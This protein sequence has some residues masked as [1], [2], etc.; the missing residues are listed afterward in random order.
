MKRNYSKNGSMMLADD[1][2]KIQFDQNILS[3]ALFASL[4]F[5]TQKHVCIQFYYS[6]RLS[7]L[8][9]LLKS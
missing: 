2:S 5:Q 4:I 7:G 1:V 8:G 9:K 6:G 3:S